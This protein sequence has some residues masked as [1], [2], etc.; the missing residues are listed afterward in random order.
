MKEWTKDKEKRILMKYRFTLTIKI[1]RV[2]AAIGLIWLV[3]MI[4]VNII[5]DQTHLDKKHTFYSRLAL[6]WTHPNLSGGFGVPETTEITSFLT[7]KITFPVF[8]MVGK[9]EQ[10]IGEVKLYKPLLTTFSNRQLTLQ[11]R[12]QENWFDFYLPER[13]DSGEKLPSHD[14]PNV[15]RTLTEVH[16]GTVAD[17]AFSTKSYMSPSELLDILT[18]YDIDVIWM[19]LYSGEFK[20]FT[21]NSWGGDGQLAVSPFGLVGGKEISEDYLSQ[22][23]LTLS[24][25]N[26]NE[27]EQL[28]LKNMAYLLEKERKSYYETF[29]GLDHLQARYDYLKNNGFQVYGAVVTGPVKELLKLKDVKEISNVQLGKLDYWNWDQ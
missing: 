18:P 25:E 19:P 24:K 1:L 16:S 29:L 22:S 11:N 23:S 21:P 12:S 2:L 7:Q 6:E 13:P 17:F 15:W 27:S 14:S 4:G 9:A 8:R 28:M 20:E 5:Y 26:L 3:Y 10:Q